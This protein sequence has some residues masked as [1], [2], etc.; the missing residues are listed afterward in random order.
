MDGLRFPTWWPPELRYPCLVEANLA[1]A[2]ESLP[3]ELV[4]LLAVPVQLK[5]LLSISEAVL[6]PQNSPKATLYS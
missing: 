3:K 4:H 1:S 5:N 6:I 2:F